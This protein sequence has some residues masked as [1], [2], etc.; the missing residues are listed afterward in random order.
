MVFL[1]N[2]R[3]PDR[4]TEE[5]YY[6][7]YPPELEM[8]CYS[9]NNV[10]PFKLFPPKGL[11]ELSFAPITILYGGNGS[12][13]STLLNLIAAK[14]GVPGGAINKTPFFDRYLQ[15]CRG[16]LARR[17]QSLP[18]ESLRITSDD[19]FDFLLDLRAV[20]EGVAH[21]RA[22]LFAAYAQQ[23]EDPMAPLRSL[24][25]Y[26]A[27]KEQAEAKRKTKSQ[28]VSRRLPLE[29]DGR[30]NGESAFV[31]FTRKIREDALY[32][33]DEPENSLSAA[34]QT[35][36]AQFLEDSARFYGCQ[37]IISTHSPFLLSIKGAR[38]YDLDALPVAVRPW[39]ELSAVRTYYDFFKA[40]EGE[41]EDPG[42]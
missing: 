22:D 40:H 10:Y 4:V 18:P 33:L 25:E 30:S 38:I 13:K 8:Q 23:R 27:F 24:E 19:V 5:S 12:G 36:L 11:R 15:F 29:W 17:V 26:E 42:R 7:S 3:L 14:M 6:L 41:F 21:R 37:L 31:Y 28:Y 34:L 2:F 9:H 20:N 1:E 32:L 39:T 35:E 16:T